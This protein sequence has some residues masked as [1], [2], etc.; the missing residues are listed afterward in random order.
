MGKFLT[1]EE[2]AALALKRRAEQVEELRRA[3]DEQRKMRDDFAKEGKKELR[4]IER[5]MRDRRDPRGKDRDKNRD[6]D[7]DKKKDEAPGN[8]KEKAAI[9]DRYLGAERKKKRIRRQNDRKFIF[10]WE[11]GDDTS[12]DYNKLYMNRHNLQFFGR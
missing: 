5:D 8:D 12:V 10:D 9:R 3:Q 6:K 1:K 7:R 11:A 2:R 4:D